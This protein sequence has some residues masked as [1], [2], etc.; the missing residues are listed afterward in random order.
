VEA[1]IE[2]FRP[3]ANR[4][5]DAAAAMTRSQVQADLELHKETL[6]KSLESE[7][8]RLRTELM[9]DLQA[10]L[11]SLQAEM[12]GSVTLLSNKIE[13]LRVSTERAQMELVQVREESAFCLSDGCWRRLRVCLPGPEPQGLQ[14]GCREAAPEQGG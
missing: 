11:S 9:G 4:D 12:S 1:L 2:A 10:E 6:G 5:A 14:G 13:K 3:G 7:C 8:L